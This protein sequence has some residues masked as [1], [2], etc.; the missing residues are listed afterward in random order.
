MT[1]RCDVGM[2]VTYIKYLTACE[3]EI[4]LNKSQ[5]VLK[6]AVHWNMYSFSREN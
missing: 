4:E 6:V 1:L 5:F 2:C 3:Q